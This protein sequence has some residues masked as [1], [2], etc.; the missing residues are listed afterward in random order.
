M[1]KV[2]ARYKKW[3]EE[4]IEKPIDEWV[5]KH[6]EKCKKHHWYDPR[7]WF[8]WIE[9]FFV[10]VFRWVVV[11]VGK[12][13]T[14]L[15]CQVVTFAVDFLATFVGLILSIPILGRLVGLVWATVIEIIWRVV[16]IFDVIAGVLGLHLPKKLRLCIIIL[17]DDKGPMAT[18]QSLQP[19][20]D[21]ARHIYKDAANVELIVGDIHTIQGAAPD[22]VLDPPCG[23]GTLW[24]DLWIEGTFYENNANVQCFDSAILR[25]IGYAAPVVVFVVRDV[26]G[27]KGCSLGPFVDYVLVEGKDPVCL[28]HEVSHACGLWHVAD[29]ANLANAD[30]GGTALREWQVEVIR[31]SR[32]VTFL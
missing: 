12:W 8:C 1:A 18:P 2:C 5:E 6:N 15:V 27:K 32:H 20:I 21:T 28:A 19:A 11:W 10:E 13:A 30:C 9:T 31:S 17:S 16:S 14:Y 7:S 22:G 23:V 3:I 24:D 26:Q 29:Q 25:L 4:K